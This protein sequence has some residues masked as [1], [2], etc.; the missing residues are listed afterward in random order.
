MV[1]TDSCQY[2]MTSLDVS[3]GSF[4]TPLRKGRYGSATPTCL[5]SL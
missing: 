1:R 4:G 5:G 3:D 2:N